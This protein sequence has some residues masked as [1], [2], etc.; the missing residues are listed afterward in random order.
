MQF[1]EA[2]RLDPAYLEARNNLGNVQLVLGNTGLA[3]QQFE[4]ALRLNPSFTPAVKGL[5]RAR[6]RKAAETKTP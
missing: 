2:I 6:A 4:E 5:E 1:S 3:I